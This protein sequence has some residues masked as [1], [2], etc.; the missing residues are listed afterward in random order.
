[1]ILVSAVLIM[2][3]LP[4]AVYGQGPDIRNL[5]TRIM[6]DFSFIG[7]PA[8]MSSILNKVDL[9]TEDV[10]TNTSSAQKPD[11]NSSMTNTTGTN[12]SSNAS[13]CFVSSG[14]VGTDQVGDNTR[15]SFEGFWSM[16]AKKHSF[17]NNINSRTYLSGDFDVDKSI[18]F[19]G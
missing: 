12:A 13:S 17:G 11:D 6:N 7:Q 5:Q 9:K 14:S 8:G 15:G 19:S 2:V 3:V 4:L 18:K 10:Q 1:M 16:Q